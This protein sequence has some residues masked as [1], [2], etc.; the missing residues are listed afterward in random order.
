[1]FDRLGQALLAQ[2]DG[3]VL[4]IAVVLDERK[5]GVHHPRAGCLAQA[6]DVLGA[7][8][9]RHCASA[10][11][12]ADSGAASVAASGAAPAS[13]AGGG[14]VGSAGAGSGGS[15]AAA[16]ERSSRAFRWA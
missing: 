16:A 3:G 10:G 7:E 9:D 15:G 2:P 11:S 5:F 4:E 6:L 1:P 14:G 8:L 13:A 12:V